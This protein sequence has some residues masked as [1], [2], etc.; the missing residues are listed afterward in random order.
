[1]S[2][3]KKKRKEKIVIFTDLDDTLL[4]RS[5]S[6]RK[7]IFTIKILN[8]EKIPIIFCSAKTKAEQEFFRKKL[9]IKHPFI[10]ENGSAIYIPRG[11]FRKKVGKKKNNYEV[12]VLGEESKKILKEIKKLKKKYKIKSYSDLS[13]KEVSKITNLNLKLAKFAKKREFGETVVEIDKKAIR[14]LKKKF[15]VAFGGRFIQL[16]GKGADKGKAVKILTKLYKEKYKKIF[17]IGIGNAENDLPMLKA[18]SKPVL[19]KNVD[20]TFAKIKLKNLYRSKGV[21]P[22]G[23][24][25]AIKRFVLNA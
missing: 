1:M 23:W 7:A 11:Y 14:E 2:S 15:N 8:R 16:Y 17:T 5:Y 25:E 13:A 6:P 9:K 24:V 10:V 4:D 3:F 18:V 12:I 20:G 19:V 21:G 22:N